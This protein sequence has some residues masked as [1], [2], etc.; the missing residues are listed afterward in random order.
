MPT[1]FHRD[2]PVAEVTPPPTGPTLTYDEAWRGS[3][4]AFPVSLSMPMDQVAWPPE[5]VVPWLLNLLPEGE[6]MRA[7]QRALGVA[8]EDVLGLISAAAGDLAGA[9]RVG[10]LRGEEGGYRPVSSPKDLER[11]RR[12][13][14]QALPRRGRRRDH[15]SGGRPRPVSYT[16]LRAHET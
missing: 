7:M 6:P 11:H 10:G 8:Q 5:V 9:L 15:E 13:A 14:A 2:S 12:V 1:L 4:D 16:H 3:C